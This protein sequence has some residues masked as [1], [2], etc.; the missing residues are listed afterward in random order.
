MGSA[1]MRQMVLRARKT[2]RLRFGT[3]EHLNG[4]MSE[5]ELERYAAL[6]PDSELLLK[7]AYDGLGLDPRT[8]LKTR[9]IA[10]TIA[11]LEGE[12]QVLGRHIAEALGYRER[13]EM[14][15]L[16]SGPGTVPLQAGG[17]RIAK[18]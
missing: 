7:Q 18:A 2:Q 17:E 10:R 6:G 4:D 1:E 15:T 16:L 9:R 8:L 13:R 14:A 12:D 5:K 11:D 3:G